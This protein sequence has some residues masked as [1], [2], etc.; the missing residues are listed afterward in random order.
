M[1]RYTSNGGASP[2][3]TLFS[4]VKENLRKVV[5]INE[6]HSQVAFG[7]G[8]GGSAQGQ[9][10]VIIGDNGRVLFTGDGGNTW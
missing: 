2:W 3:R 6:M 8:A 4:G 10:A 7:T 9:K 5:I 1:I